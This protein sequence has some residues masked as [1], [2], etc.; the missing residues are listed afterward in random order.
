MPSAGFLMLR[1]PAV[2]PEPGRLDLPCGAGLDQETIQAPEFEVSRSVVERGP[3]PAVRHCSPAMPSAM[4]GLR[5]RASIVGL[6]LHSLDP[7]RTAAIERGHAGG[8]L[9]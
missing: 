9:S 1:D 8:R 7:V 6:R 5:G 4:P 2:G 3:L